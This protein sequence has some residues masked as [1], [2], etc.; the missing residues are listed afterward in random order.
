MNT[1]T[2]NNQSFS[3]G[4]KVKIVGKC[5][6]GWDRVPL[7]TIQYFGK[8]DDGEVFISAKTKIPVVGDTKRNSKTGAYT[9]GI[10]YKD[11]IEKAF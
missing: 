1:V 6:L 10:F 8:N 5:I 3:V 2:L 11:D 9:S 4:E 7:H